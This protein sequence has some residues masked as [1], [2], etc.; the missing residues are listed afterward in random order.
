MF[1]GWYA[2]YISCLIVC[3]VRFCNNHPERWRG[4]CQGGTSSIS[5]CSVK[6]QLSTGIG[7]AF[8]FCRVISSLVNTL[9]GLGITVQ[10]LRTKTQLD[11]TQAWYWKL[12]LVIRDGQLKLCLP[13]YLAISLRL[14]HICLFW[15][16]STLLSFHTIAQ[17]SLDFS[18]LSVGI[19]PPIKQSSPSPLDPHS[20]HPQSSITFYS[21]SLC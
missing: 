16:V 3:I 14:L 7:L 13:H 11:V 6:L 15:E 1:C 9:G 8:S 19:F 4:K 5:S 2:V 20:S 21:I 18:C 12:C 10:S 17:I